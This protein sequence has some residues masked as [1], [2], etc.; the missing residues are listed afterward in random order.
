MVS[1]SAYMHVFIHTA[2]LCL[3]TGTLNPFTFKVLINIYHPITIFLIVLGLF[4]VGL[5]LLLC[6]LARGVPLAFVVYSWFGSVALLT[7]ACLESF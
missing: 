1:G 4:S 6:F 7:F 2:N 5:L 3:L